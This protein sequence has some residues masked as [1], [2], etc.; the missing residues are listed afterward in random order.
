MYF[1]QDHL[2]D[3]FILGGYAKRWPKCARISIQ[4]LM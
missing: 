1:E 4:K 2:L 3:L